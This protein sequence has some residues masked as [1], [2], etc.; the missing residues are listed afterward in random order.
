VQLAECLRTHGLPNWPDPA[1]DGSFG[2]PPSLL[3]KSPSWQ[4]ASTACQRYYP[5]GGLNVHAAS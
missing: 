2:L 4:R 3:A 1:P 5:N